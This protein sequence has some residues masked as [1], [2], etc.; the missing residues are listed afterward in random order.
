MRRAGGKGGWVRLR[1]GVLLA[2]GC[3]LAGPGAA[4]QEV[5]IPP[6]PERWVTDGPGLLSPQTRS[7]LDA[8]L[9]AYDRE[10]GRQV[11][12]W[13]GDTTGAAPPEDWAARAFE[14]WGVGRKGLDD[15][16]VLFLFA[17]DRRVRIEVGYGLEDRVPD[18]V[19]FGVV[20][21]I[22][23]PR[24][25]AGDP[26]GAVDAAVDALIT[27]IGGETEEEAGA[28]SGTA[29]QG[30]SQEPQGSL[31]GR[32]LKVVIFIILGIAFLYLLATNP[33]LALY[34][35]FSILSGGRGGG[36]GLSGGGFSGGGGRSGGGGATGSW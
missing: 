3:L 9:E 36:G 1:L 34:L 32:I 31:L 13:I 35:L 8:R 14:A 4:A 16:L 17:R 11:L 2:L 27:A 24:L 26:D 20:N 5:P 29:V 12:V 7:A 30:P 25:Q 22:L 21:R 19:A 10:T 33:A 23:S 6:A 18:A 28:P 15:G